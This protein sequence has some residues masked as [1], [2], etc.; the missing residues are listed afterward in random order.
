[1]QLK[2][3]FFPLTVTAF[4]SHGLTKSYS[5]TKKVP[6]LYKALGKYKAYPPAFTEQKN[7]EIIMLC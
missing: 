1:M 4:K 2:I 6:L 3:D 5:S 7:E